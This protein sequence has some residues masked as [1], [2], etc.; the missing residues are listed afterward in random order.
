MTVIFRS[1]EPDL[2]I[3]SG[4]DGRTIA[5]IAVPYN[6]P[7]RIN[8]QLTEQ[9]ARGAFAKQLKAGHRVR[10]TRDH[11]AQGGQVI[12]TTVLLRDDSAGLY[13]EWRVSKTSLGDETLELVR[14]GALNQLSIGFREGQNRRLPS[15]AI[16]RVT[17]EL[18]EVAVVVQGAYGEHA[19]IA[20]VRAEEEEL[21]RLARAQKLLGELPEL[22]PFDF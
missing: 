17:A 18:L 4:G 22:R 1:Y 13:G 6:H 19:A 7:Q 10:F 11:Y 12:G 21:H 2:E 8:G 3:R 16:E 14:D 5:G 9:F 15:G 20:A